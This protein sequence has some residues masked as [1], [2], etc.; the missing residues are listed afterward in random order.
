M[1]DA[2]RNIDLQNTYPT[3]H[4]MVG[5]PDFFYVNHSCICNS[6]LGRFSIV[7][8]EY[9]RWIIVWPFLIVSWFSSNVNARKKSWQERT[10]GCA[11]QFGWF[12]VSRAT[13]YTQYFFL[14]Y[15]PC[16][17]EPCSQSLKLKI[18][19]QLTTYKSTYSMWLTIQRLLCFLD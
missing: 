5:E 11:F 8:K 7:I 6:A 9:Q 19:I 17:L 12:I 13:Y 14:L 4:L 3:P 1:C 15:G 10:W 2:L 16:E 18:H